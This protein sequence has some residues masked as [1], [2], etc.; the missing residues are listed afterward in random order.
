MRQWMA[1]PKP[2][3]V[4]SFLGLFLA[5][6][7]RMLSLSYV[8]QNYFPGPSSVGP[9]RKIDKRVQESR[10]PGAFPRLDWGKVEA[11]QAQTLQL[12]VS[13]LWSAWQL[14]QKQNLALQ[15]Y[16]MRLDKEISFSDNF[17]SP[18]TFVTWHLAMRN[19]AVDTYTPHQ[20]SHFPRKDQE[21]KCRQVP[22]AWR[23]SSFLPS[24][25]ERC[26]NQEEFGFL[27][28]QEQGSI[29]RECEKTLLLS[30][31]NKHAGFWSCEVSAEDAAPGLWRSFHT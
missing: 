1:L 28:C 5:A 8:T 18:D 11:D 24:I 14:T 9:Q 21:F 4:F 19:G 20:R 31:K 25:E 30:L 17:K 3:L 22:E 23:T 29:A 27:G 10:K 12:L 15:L 26:R 7:L 16:R 2:S 13:S 6:N